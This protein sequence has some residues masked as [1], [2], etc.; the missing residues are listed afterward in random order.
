MGLKNFKIWGVFLVAIVVIAFMLFQQSNNN[1]KELEGQA[2]RNME[3]VKGHF[4]SAFYSNLDKALFSIRGLKNKAN[5]KIEIELTEDVHKVPDIIVKNSEFA[6]PIN[7][8]FVKIDQHL[9]FEKIFLTDVSGRVLYPE[10]ELGKNLPN[11]D[12]MESDPFRM[13]VVKHEIIYKDESYL[14]YFTPV[15][16]ENLRFY[17]GGVI[18][19][20]YY[21]SI[22][23]RVDFTNLTILV[24]L[25]AMMFFS[26]P[27]I[28]LF[29]LQHGDKLT[30][31]GVYNVGLSLIGI[32]LM[33]GFG[34]SFFKQHHPV[35]EQKHDIDAQ[36]IRDYYVDFLDDK[37][38]TMA[39]WKAYKGGFNE[40]INIKN[41]GVVSQLY[42]NG[43]VTDN[44]KGLIDDPSFINLKKREYFQFF[45]DKSTANQ[46]NKAKNQVSFLGSHYSL[47]SAIIESVIS[48]LDTTKKR[49]EAITFSWA[50]DLSK[51]DSKRRF[52]LFKEDGL[53]I[54]KSKKVDAPVDNLKDILS[55]SKWK[56]IS[57]IM[58]LNSDSIYS[59]TW[60]LPLY[61][62][63]HPFEA[64]LVPIKIRGEFDQPLWM[65]YLV[66]GHLEHV[67]SSLITF[68]TAFL[69]IIYLLIL[70]V[71][72]FLNK[73]IKPK[74]KY[75]KW[76]KFA[77]YY[78]FPN[79]K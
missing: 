7:N 25:L 23:R 66:D 41:D 67:F 79:Q 44:R 68:E 61:L 37:R 11:F 78:L 12:A 31:F 28:S 21:D 56:E 5:G 19:K 20:S 74:S 27:I 60:E 22:G 1:R 72:S 17:L 9:F 24:Y 47:D 43:F 39:D 14:L 34:F 3:L 18:Q 32:M 71:I 55:E 70:S 30:K 36:E 46:F 58:K 45:E 40:L 6:I 65:I 48:K 59:Q 26:M 50:K 51:Y 57:S 64:V 75:Q 77:Y 33:L 76:D 16:I 69:L 73:L 15:V 54:H 42:I 8:L 10:I 4:Q 49:I 35:S 62:D 2:I 52:L 38:E 63:G 53:V 13:P 29:G